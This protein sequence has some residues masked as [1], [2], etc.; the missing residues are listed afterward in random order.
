MQMTGTVRIVQGE[1]AYVVVKRQSACGENC[2]NCSGC[3]D[4]SNEILAKN[5]IGAKAGDSVLV[6]ME[7]KK[8][9]MA[10]F[11]FY[12]MPLILFFGI[13]T[14][15]YLLNFSDAISLTF[16]VIGALIFYVLLYFYDKRSK[17]KFQHE[18]I[19]IN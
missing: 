18:I 11:L 14:A 17:N 12:M 7:T 15:F 10:A 5:N 6:S 2:G 1:C 8:V 3:K 19:K 16:S 13:Y 4:K 9:L